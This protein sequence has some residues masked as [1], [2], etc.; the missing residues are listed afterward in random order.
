M[1]VF[2]VYIFLMSVAQTTLYFQIFAPLMPSAL[3]R[4]EGNF[5]RH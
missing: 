1:H 3:K 4:L 2:A 5:S